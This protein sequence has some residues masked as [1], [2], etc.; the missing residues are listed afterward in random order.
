MG[1]PSGEEGSDLRAG[2][3]GA[4]FACQGQSICEAWRV[5]ESPGLEAEAPRRASC[6]GRRA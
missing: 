2:Q 5:D 4:Q 6:T 1:D 3:S